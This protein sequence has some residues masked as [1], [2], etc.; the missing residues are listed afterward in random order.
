MECP[1]LTLTPGC[2]ALWEA[3]KAKPL[4]KKRPLCACDLARPQGARTPTF[5][6]PN[7]RSPWIQASPSEVDPQHVLAGE[8]LLAGCARH[9]QAVL[10]LTQ[11]GPA[12]EVAT[13]K[14][15]H[16]LLSEVGRK[17]SFAGG[18][19]GAQDAPRLLW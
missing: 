12:E 7:N 14:L 15:V 2:T 10:L 6:L 11:A 8:R 16:G 19:L 1:S 3:I 13:G 9:R 18:T 17:D 5:A 4:G